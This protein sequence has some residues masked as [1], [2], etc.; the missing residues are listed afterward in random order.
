M[1][2]DSALTSALIA[3]YLCN[4]ASLRSRPDVGTPPT[5]QVP[6]G[7][8]Y[9]SWLTGVVR[10]T[11]QEAMHVLYQKRAVMVAFWCRTERRNVV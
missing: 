5:L 4:A 9:E 10:G 8:I 6:C 7:S 3:S 11:S 1:N 2:S